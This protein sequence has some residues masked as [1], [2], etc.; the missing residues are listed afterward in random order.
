MPITLNGDGAISGLT[1]TGISAVQTV[2]RAAMPIGSVLQVVQ[3]VKSD[4]FTT[5][6]SSFIDVTGLSVTI[7][8]TSASNR[9]LVLYSSSLA[10]ISGQ[11]SCSMRLVR[12]STGIYIGD[13]AG[14]RTRA[15][16]MYWSDIGMVYG[17]A[18]VNG[19]F[20]DSPATT[21]ATTYKLQVLSAYAETVYINRNQNDG[22]TAVISRVPSSITVME[23]SG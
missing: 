19:I 6:S 1:A 13:T 15:S 9:I 20:L 23:I 17:T 2:T 18:P 10:T 22:D 7:T 3:T 11:Y 21:S 4:T 8:P 5:T 16:N 12:D 14:S